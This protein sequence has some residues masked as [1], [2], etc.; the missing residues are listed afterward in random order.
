MARIVTIFSTVV[1]FLS[2][3]PAKA[4]TLDAQGRTLINELGCKAC[5]VFD[6]QGGEIGPSLDAVGSRLNTGEIR[7]KLL[8]P[9]KSVPNSI[10]PS[11]S[12]LSTDSLESLVEFLSRQKHP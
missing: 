1:L 10:M 7:Q 6:G 12:H 3:V 11:F 5:H 8:S 9:K 2:I 4:A